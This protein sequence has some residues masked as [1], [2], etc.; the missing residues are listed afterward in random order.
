[1]H[2]VS[3]Q[4]NTSAASRTAVPMCGGIVRPTQM[5]SVYMLTSFPNHHELLACSR[6]SVVAFAQGLSS[7]V[8]NSLRFSVNQDVPE[9]EYQLCLS[10]QRDLQLRLLVLSMHPGMDMPVLRPYGT[11]YLCI[12]GQRQLSSPPA[13]LRRS[14][15]HR[16]PPALRMFRWCFL[17]AE[18]RS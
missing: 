3:D 6:P 13:R 17:T 18:T 2:H 16:T 8:Y 10:K 14:G 5:S 11:V 7:Y 9:V 15:S 12:Y 4:R 1:M